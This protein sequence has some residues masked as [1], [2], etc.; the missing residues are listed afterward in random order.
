MFGIDRTANARHAFSVKKVDAESLLREALESV[1]VATDDQI[2]NGADTG[3]DFVTVLG[4]AP[5]RVEFRSLVDLG[6]AQRL[7]SKPGATPESVLMVVGE[8]I[9]DSAKEFLSERNVGFFDLR[10]HLK[11]RTPAL[12]IDT[13][14]PTRR[15][16]APS[17]SDPLAGDVGLEVGVAVLMA[18][19]DRHGVRTLARALERSPSSVSVV[20]QR[21]RRDG[22]IDSSGSLV[23]TELFWLLA[24]R[25]GTEST[26]LAEM[27]PMDEHSRLSR[28]LRLDFAGSEA[29][30]WALTDAAAA[31][32]FGAPLAVRADQRLDFYVPNLTAMRRAESLLGTA[33]TMSTTRARLRVAPVAAVTSCRVKL[34]TRQPVWP[35]AHPLFVA[36]DLARDVGR[37]REILSDWTPPEGWDRVW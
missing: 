31:L 27:P 17:G 15:R 5:V 1:G 13:A 22:Y 9:L 11:V 4:D 32:H 23:G 24:D 35:L 18:P 10:G 25:W 33:S 20:M 29:E 16:A 26:M 12:I 34:R 30:G 2:L 21:L 14:V 6:A 28:A 7:A 8:R 37:G 36:L 19:K 3:A